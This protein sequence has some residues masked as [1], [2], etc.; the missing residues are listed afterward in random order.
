MA[1]LRRRDVSSADQLTSLR[2][3]HCIHALSDG[4]AQTQLRL[5]LTGL[6]KTGVSS[7]VYC[8][9]TRGVKAPEG[10]PVFQCPSGRHYYLKSFRAIREVLRDFRPDVVHAWLPASM[11]IPALVEAKCAGTLSVFSYRGQMR[12]CRP[13]HL[14]EFACVSALA[15]RIV[16]NND[17]R[18]SA[19]PYRWL[20]A[21]KDGVEIANAVKSSLAQPPSSAMD[22]CEKKS[23]RCILYVGRLTRS[24]NWPTLLQALALLDGRHRWRLSVFGDG[25]QRREFRSAIAKLGLASKVSMMGYVSNVVELMKSA[26]MLVMPSWSEGMPNVLLEAFEMRL[27]CIASDIPSH[28]QLVGDSGAAI[29]FNPNSVPDL[30]SA[31]EAVLD[32]S[33]DLDRMV[34]AGKAIADRYSI[35]RMVD[36]YSA[37]YRRL[38]RSS[39]EREA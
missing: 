14:I 21:S 36:Q 27:P 37:M 2:V 9:E 39:R 31:I 33:V 12:F 25:E 23:E 19:I 17:V 29:L 4:G 16:T 3:L 13:L 38:V 34:V 20:Y 35:P 8:V 11:T 30:V 1:R 18:N 26:D 6:A 24:K 22:A 7:A 28:R 10:T 32:R 15:D 5:L